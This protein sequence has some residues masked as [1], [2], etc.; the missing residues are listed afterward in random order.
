MGERKRKQERRL[1]IPVGTARM[2]HLHRTPGCARMESGSGVQGRGGGATSLSCTQGGEVE[3]VLRRG[4]RQG[5]HKRV[6]VGCGER[7]VWQ[8][9]RMMAKILYCLG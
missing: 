3:L 4:K 7:G 1:N 9:L 5:E 8:L 2:A 6:S